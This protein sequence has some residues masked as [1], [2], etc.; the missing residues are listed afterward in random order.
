MVAQ[1]ASFK[2]LQASVAQVI[3]DQSQAHTD[4]RQRLSVLE[5]GVS[6]IDARLSSM[7][8]LLADSKAAA[9]NDS[10]GKGRFGRAFSS[11]SENGSGSYMRGGHGGDDKKEEE[12]QQEIA[13]LASAVR[14]LAISVGHHNDLLQTPS[15]S[16]A[17]VFNGKDEAWPRTGE[18]SE[19]PSAHALI[20][21]YNAV[22]IKQVC[23]DG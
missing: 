10:A 15:L 11:S 1:R 20:K 8:S 7:L 23:G 3:K 19:D 21:A 13:A 16:A 17:T 18:S 4:L 22:R 12:Q 14:Q 5:G 9:G 6:A 2:Q